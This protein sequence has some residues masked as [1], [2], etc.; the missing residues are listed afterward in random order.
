MRSVTD[1]YTA[2]IAE[3]KITADAAQEALLPQLDRLKQAVVAPVRRGL[4][5]KAPP[6]PKGLYI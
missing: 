4:F 1:R 6:A 5:R 3:Q 2:L